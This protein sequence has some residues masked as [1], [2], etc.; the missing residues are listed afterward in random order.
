M[1]DFFSPKYPFSE[2]KNL[3]SLPSLDCNVNK[4]GTLVTWSLGTQTVTYYPFLSDILN[5]E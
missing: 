5:F 4:A 1:I 2:D 3:A